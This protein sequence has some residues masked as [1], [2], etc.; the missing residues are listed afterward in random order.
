MNARGIP[1]AH[2]IEDVDA[3]IIGTD[4]DQSLQQLQQT[5]ALLTQGGRGDDTIACSK[6]RFM[7][8]NKRQ[9]RQGLEE[10][11]P[12]LQ[13]TLAM[14]ETL[15]RKKD[16]EQSFDTTFELSDTLYA[17]G[18]VEHVDEVY[19]WL[20]VSQVQSVRA[21]GANTMLSYPLSAALS[22][23]SEKLITA[24]ASLRNVREDL[25]SLREQITITEVNVARVYNWD[26]KR[27][28][29]IR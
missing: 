16:A 5:L 10:K 1:K 9:R 2:F 17:T 15:Q 18:C 28:R 26:V 14:I 25:D 21:R 6:Y 20:G 19:V 4:P 22:L 8:N 27:R 29:E 24:Q 7:E 13:R 12:E 23:L 11:V 3:F